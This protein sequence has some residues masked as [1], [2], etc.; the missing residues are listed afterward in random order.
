VAA[1][2]PNRK[3]SPIREFL[4]DD[5]LNA[6]DAEAFG[7]GDL[8]KCPSSKSMPNETKFR[9]RNENFAC[10]LRNF[11]CERKTFRSGARKPLKS[12]GREIGNFAVRNDFKAL[13]GVRL[14][15]V[16]THQA[17]S[18]GAAFGED[19]ACDGEELETSLHLG[20][21]VGEPETRGSEIE[22]TLRQLAQ[23]LD[24]P[25]K[26]G[27]RRR[28]AGVDLCAEQFQRLLEARDLQH[29]V[30]V[31]RIGFASREFLGDDLLNAPDA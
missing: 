4:G 24:D 30:I 17:T 23:P 11:A 8:F 16:F 5:L 3:D 2:R 15:A 28:Y 13:R 7:L 19:F 10:E 6:P 9:L 27:D 1:P 18:P 20:H 31:G 29:R 21:L 26:S 12:L 22:L 25:Q 14:R